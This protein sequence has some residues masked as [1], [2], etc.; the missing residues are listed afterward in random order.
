MIAPIPPTPAVAATGMV[1]GDEGLLLSSVGVVV[2]LGVRVV[3]VGVVV[4]VGAG[5][6]VVVASGVGSGEGSGVGVEV[7]P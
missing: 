4:V 5:S 3:V 2:W 6:R 7:A 1:Q